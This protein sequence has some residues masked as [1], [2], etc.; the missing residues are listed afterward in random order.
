MPWPNARD[1]LY[2]T[3]ADVVVDV[4]EAIPAEACRIV[5]DA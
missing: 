4:D 5:R 1:P 2:A 3:V